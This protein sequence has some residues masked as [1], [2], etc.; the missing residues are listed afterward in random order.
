VCIVASLILAAS[1]GIAAAPA[2]VAA[3]GPCVGDECDGGAWLA[4]RG[5][6]N[7]GSFWGMYS[8]HNCTNYV[9]WRLIDAGVERPRTNPGN[10]STWAERA[11]LDGY[12]VDEVPSVGAVAQ[13]DSSA[14]MGRN[15]HV[16]YVE[17]VYD[18]GTILISEDFWRGGSQTGSLTYRVI[19]ASAPSHYIHYQDDTD[20]LRI[21]SLTDS[22]WDSTAT[23]IDI[24]PLAMSAVA[25]PEVGVNVFYASDGELREAAQ[26]ASG[27]S[28]TSTG[29]KSNATSLSVVTMGGAYPY[30]MSLDDGVLLMSVRNS[31]GWQRMSTG[32]AITGE[33]SAVNLGG[34]WPTVYL[35][36]GGGLWRLWGDNEGWHSEPTGVEVWGPVSAVVDAT[37]WPVVFNVHNGMIFRSW[38]D[39]LGWHTESTGVP[40]NGP[41]SAVQTA[42][43]PQVFLVQDEIVYRIQT[44][45]LSWTKTATELDAGTSLA[46]IDQGGP[47]P[48]VLQAG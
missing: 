25:L 21:A 27:W 22:T 4:A 43:G 3:D 18:D 7:N 30:V 48:L 46:V 38:Q 16:A 44:D 33:V 45:G 8:G 42:T 10:A 11:S 36:Q 17:Q 24:Q 1:L 32:F 15:G 31:S 14:G 40:A 26:G 6:D 13:W 47:A 34:L 2:A 9:A 39:D 35:S 23:G 37:G 29:L 28:L 5:E 20:W 19:P 12:L 41:I